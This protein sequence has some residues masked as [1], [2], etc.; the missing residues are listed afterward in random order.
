MKSRW[1]SLMM[2]MLALGVFVLPGCSG[3]ADPLPMEDAE[4]VDDLADDAEATLGESDVEADEPDRGAR[5]GTTEQFDYLFAHVVE[6]NLALPKNLRGDAF[7]L[8]N[9]AEQKVLGADV[10]MLERGCLF[11]GEFEHPFPAWREG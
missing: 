11:V 6:S 9:K 5:L 1:L 7:L 8:A 2:L 10:T 3:G 4:L